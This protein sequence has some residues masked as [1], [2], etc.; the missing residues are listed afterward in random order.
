MSKCFKGRFQESSFARLSIAVAL[1]TF[2]GC[3]RLGPPLPPEVFSPQ[4]VQQ[5]EATAS[6]EGVTINWEAPELDRRNRDLESIDGYQV[7]RIEIAQ[8]SSLG[9]IELSE[10]DSDDDDDDAE[11]DF[12]EDTH[13]LELEK[14]QKEARAAGKSARKVSVD[15]TTKQFRFVDSSVLPGKFYRYEIVPVNQGGV[16]GVVDQKIE[17]QFRGELSQPRVMKISG[18]DVAAPDNENE[19]SLD[20]DAEPQS[21]Q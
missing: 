8:A 9:I 17:V 4:A 18:A 19:F 16:E 5:L 11:L 3:G 12:I 13:L 7:N 20:E 6:A 10:P 21:V 2:A 15:P 14:L 1:L